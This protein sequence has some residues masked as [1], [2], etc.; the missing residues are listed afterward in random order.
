MP[1]AGLGAVGARTAGVCCVGGLALALVSDTAGARCAP[2]EGKLQR[3]SSRGLASM[4][5]LGA[6]HY[7]EMAPSASQSRLM[8]A[9]RVL[10]RFLSAEDLDG[11]NVEIVPNDHHAP[12]AIRFRVPSTAYLATSDVLAGVLGARP[13]GTKPSFWL[14]ETARLSPMADAMRHATY[15]ICDNHHITRV[16]TDTDADVVVQLNL[17]SGASSIS[18]QTTTLQPCDVRRL[19]AACKSVSQARANGADQLLAPEMA[20]TEAYAEEYCAS[21]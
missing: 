14:F 11:L 1:L 3:L 19:A 21:A 13:N 18:L 12:I 6:H 4:R 9:N 5:K 10:Q 20:T 8:E 7:S 16:K 15:S 17:E 2:S